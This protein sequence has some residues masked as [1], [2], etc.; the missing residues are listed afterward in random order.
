M[1][2]QTVLL[3]DA[4]RNLGDNCRS[5]GLLKAFSEANPEVETV[6]WL[7]PEIEGLL[8]GLL[9]QSGAVAR[10]IVAPR[11]P[12]QTYALNHRIIKHL[13]SHGLPWHWAACPPGQGPDGQSFSRVIPSGEVWLSAKLWSGLSLDDPEEVNQGEVLAQ[14]LDLTPDQVSRVLPLFGRPAPTGDYVT[15]GLARPD[16]ADPKQLP[17]QRREQVWQ[18]VRRGQRP[19]A[20]VELQDWA[21]PP[22]GIRDLRALSL[23][24]KVEV[25]NQARCHIGLDGGLVHFAAACGCP[26]LAF[27]AGP[28]DNPGL[29][30]G[31]WP[32]SGPRGEHQY[33]NDFKLFIEAVEATVG[34]ERSPGEP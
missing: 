26:T 33:F 7:T 28:G 13:F 10:F 2:G 30:F 12:R 24:E 16:P 25:F 11:T 23:E 27:Y 14:L 15:V 21:P 6:C 34:A 31:P 22:P 4:G 5:F 1:P 20:A 3:F 9:R 19:A 18:A 32:R 29:S 8:G 17:P